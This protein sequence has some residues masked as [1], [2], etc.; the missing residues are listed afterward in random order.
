MLRSTIR[1]LQ[2]AEGGGKPA[3]SRV[4]KTSLPVDFFRCCATHFGTVFHTP[5]IIGIRTSQ[6]RGLFLPEG[7]TIEPNQP[8]ASIPL[9]KIVTNERILTSSFA[10]PKITVERVEKAIALPEFRSMAPQLHLGVQMASVIHTLPDPSRLFSQEE[11]DLSDAIQVKEMMPWARIVD[12]EDFNE[13]FVFNM[14]AAT[15]DTWQKQSYNELVEGFAKVTAELQQQL[16]LPYSAN[17][18]RRISRLVLARSEHF[19]SADY[20]T[21]NKYVRKF[22]RLMGTVPKQEVA[23]VPLLDLVN[24]SNRPNVGVRIGRSQALNGEPAVTIHS[25]TRIE[26]G[27]E[28]CRHYNF[29]LTRPA[30]LFRYG[31][32]PFD[33][34]SMVDNNSA[35]E[36]LTKV[37]LNSEASEV[38]EKRRK[39]DDEVRKLEDMFKK[40]KSGRK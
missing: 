16:E 23:L 22:Q 3:I 12:D 13:K 38:L 28:I 40:A 10:D 6:V 5:L 35:D 34:I 21:T 37:D 27:Q 11:Q 19:P 17:H 7:H 18:L 4:K 29:A 26:G 20:Y 30:A 25:L 33:M 8:I 32:L 2:S 14:Y 31:F 1:F 9:N 39:E 36:H 24:H 15:L